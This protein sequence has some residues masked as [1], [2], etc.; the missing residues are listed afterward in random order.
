MRSPEDPIPDRQPRGSGPRGQV[1]TPA[2]RRA[3][4]LSGHYYASRRRANFHF[5]ADALVAQGWEV[6][7]ATTQ[8]SPISRL[9]GD[10]RFE[11]PVQAEANRPV[12]VR[13]GL[14]SHVWYTP[15]HVFHLRH[16]LLDRLSQ[17]LAALW[18]RLPMP[19]LEEAL[20]RADLVMVESTGALLLVERIRR[21]NP[22]A[23]LVYRVS[24][25]IRNLGQHRAVIAAEERVA[26]LFDL[27]STPS[28]Y[29]FERFAAL[30]TARL[31]P[32]GIDAAAFDA[33]CPD[34]YRGLRG[35]GTGG[36][37]LHAVSVGHSFYDPEL[38]AVAA[39][40]FPH[41]TFHVIGRVPRTGDRPNIRWY[42]EMPFRET[43]PYIVHADI[44]L[45]PYTYREGA[46]TLADSSLKLMQYTWC[47]LPAVAPDFATR[48]DRPHVVGYRQGDRASIR[49]ALVAAAKVDRAGISRAGIA[50]WDELARRIVGPDDAPA[51][52]A[53]VRET[54]QDAPR[55]AAAGYGR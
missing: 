13:P 5:L 28:R 4:L 36:D 24:D 29:S 30:G 20:R 46:E 19:G 49:H 16:P 1:E 2:P 11:Y 21:L 22:G 54:G 37:G 17:P 41:W 55:R 8:I 32:H 50:G 6:T 52:D 40:Q 34:P 7:F 45:A 14:T 42:G 33:P 43:I 27:I 25:D 10:P 23:R 18:A 51:D 26:P 9:R 31:H 44:G 15:Y 39:E 35:S 3:V 47:R 53:P 12:T 38:V 48:P